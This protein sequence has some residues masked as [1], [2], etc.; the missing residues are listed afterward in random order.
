MFVQSYV[1]L[2]ETE[3]LV[4]YLKTADDFD[5]TSQSAVAA[6][7]TAFEKSYFDVQDVLMKQGVA[8]A[9]YRDDEGNHPIHLLAEKGNTSV[10]VCLQN[11]IPIDLENSAGMTPL[12]L[13]VAHNQKDM[14]QYLI[15]NKAKIPDNETDQK[16]QELLQEKPHHFCCHLL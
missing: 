5:P 11:G 12:Q 14:V 9:D 7:W 3:S 6:L 8:N 15:N 1:E 4:Y 10:G 16:I 13:A 2:N